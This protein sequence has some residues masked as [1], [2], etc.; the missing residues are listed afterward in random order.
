[1][2]RCTQTGMVIERLRADRAFQWQNV[3]HW[4]EPAASDVA[5]ARGATDREV[6]AERTV[7]PPEALAEFIR[8]FGDAVR[9]KYRHYEATGEAE[10]FLTF[11]KSARALFFKTT[12]KRLGKRG[13]IRSFAFVGKLM[14]PSASSDEPIVAEC[15]RHGVLLILG[16]RSGG[17]PEAMMAKI[18]RREALGPVRMRGTTVE[19]EAVW[20][21]ARY[22]SGFQEWAGRGD[23]AGLALMRFVVID[24][25]AIARWEGDIRR[26]RKRLAPYRDRILAQRAILS[27]DPVGIEDDE[28]IAERLR[29]GEDRLQ[30]F[31]VLP[32]AERPLARSGDDRDPCVL[33]FAKSYEAL[34]ELTV[35]VAVEGI[36]HLG[37]VQGDGDDVVGLFVVTSHGQAS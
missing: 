2:L 4:G 27:D 18:V 32:R 13:R 29:L 20:V 34:V 24:E 5:R 21:R 7:V 26:V 14:D 15:A 19:R 10:S 3:S 31:E 36:E 8:R 17:P 37:P 33:V 30:L 1:M 16:Q 28:G 11:V 9:V 12:G 23:V 35:H 22:I 6:D 25:D